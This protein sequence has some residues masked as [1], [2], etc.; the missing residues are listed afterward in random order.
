[1]ELDELT[2]AGALDLF[3]RGDSSAA[4][5][6]QAHIDRIAEIDRAGPTLRSVLELNPDAPGAAEACDR[7]RRQ[8]GP[9]PPLNGIPILVKDSIDTADNTMTSA[10]SLAMVGHFAERDAAVVDRLRK[11]GAVILGKANMTEW[12]YMRSARTCS[13]WSSRGGQIRNPHVLDRTPS[14]SS[15]GSAVAVAAG[16]CMGALGAE[17]DGSI[18]RPSSA[19]GIAGIKPT[20]GLVSRT[21]VMP[22]AAPQDTAGPMARTVADVALL[23]TVIAGPDPEDPATLSEDAPKAPDFTSFLA[24]DA[25]RGARL[26]VARDLMGTHEGVDR[27]IDDAI[28]VLRE[29]GAEI[30]D[31]A[32]GAWTPFFGEAETELCLYGFKDGI[33]RYL[34]TRPNS[35][36]KSLA[37]VMAF[38]EANADT[39]MPYFPQDLFERAQAKGGLND[40]AYRKAKEECRRM[41]RTDGIDKVLAEHRLDAIIAPT[42]GTPPWAIDLLVGDHIVGGCSAPPAMAGYP[43]VTVPAGLCHGLPVALSFFGKAWQDGKMLGYA[44]AFEQATKARPIP[45]FRATVD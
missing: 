24:E 12:S 34:A 15:G 25:L 8:D 16:L 17:V 11:A 14:G 13:G 23:L 10:G 28:D 33:D 26:G 44:F 9:A 29:L 4:E 39:V 6:C 18:V 38:N 19:N 20:V 5:L 7:A 21:G 43:H 27:V 2:I 45:A 3:E 36:M 40:E 31:P 37:D 30:V 42:D 35:P 32:I 22:V 1:M 41:S